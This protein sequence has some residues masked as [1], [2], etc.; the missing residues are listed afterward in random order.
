MAVLKSHRGTGAGKLLVLALEKQL[1]SGE[2][3]AGLKA[4]GLEEVLVVANSQCYAEGE[5]M[6]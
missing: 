4:R 1:A 2:G 6:R 5:S 3:K